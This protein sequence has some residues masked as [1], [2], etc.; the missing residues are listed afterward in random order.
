M[1]GGRRSLIAFGLLSAI[2]TACPAT[3]QSPAV[4]DQIVGQ[5]QATA[6]GWQGTLRAL[7]LNTFYIL[8]VI[9]LAWCIAR[10]ALGR[11]DFSEWLG[12]LV[13]QVMFLGFFL[14][15]LQNSV[16][17]STAIVNSFRTAAG[18][19][20]GVGIAP[21]EVFTAGVKLATTVL[22]QISFYNPGASAGFMI[23]GIVILVCFAL[24]AAGMVLALVE[25]YIIISAGV[26][27]MA[28]GA[29][30]WTKDFAVSTIRYAVSVGAKLFIMQLLLSVG[31]SFVQ[32][33]ANT[34]SA[35]QMDNSVLCVLI[36]A[37]IVLLAL[38][39]IIPDTFQRMINGS[40]FGSGSAL[41][42]AA[43]AVGGGVAA[44]AAVAVGAP[45]AAAQAARLASSQLDAKEAA[46][47]PQQTGVA[48]AA[49]LLGGTGK[50]L[51]SAA[52]SDV[53]RRL[54]GTGSPRGSA[55][56]RM[57]ADMGN[58]R[59]LLADDMG[60]PRPSAAPA[61][62]AAASSSSSGGTLSAASAPAATSSSEALNSVINAPSSA[63]EDARTEPWMTQSGGFN[64]MS[65][66]HQA[67]AERSYARWA[68]AKPEL[69]A[70]HD[71]RDY[72]GYVQE[73]QAERMQVAALVNSSSPSS[74]TP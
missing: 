68:E 5:F 60:A 30:R 28:F 46:G 64:G 16:T 32:A 21:S 41:I 45:A 73:K 26:L 9:E 61:A 3:A 37:S 22:A 12:E 10:L 27:F 66:E 72:V 19:A 71:L 43:A 18:A 49:S 35:G 56:W 34:N 2:L 31:T 25:S 58:Q 38:V 4:L 40:S 62:T 54:A 29:S 50:N 70:R 13:N 20:G 59:R 51:A 15:L 23:A 74:R 39:K 7:A 1:S 69:A 11:A 33:W 52:A 36:G 24:M 6:T 63:D 65:S 47:A 67:S 57:A 14:A 17:W 48:R 53:G 44:A 8:A 55:P 42:G